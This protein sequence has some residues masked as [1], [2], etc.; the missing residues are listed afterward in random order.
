MGPVF[1]TL[2]KTI[3][4][5]KMFISKKKDKDDFECDLLELDSITEN[6]GEADEIVYYAE[7]QIRD[8]F[9]QKQRW[10]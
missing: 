7:S 10:K 8:W 2:I 4:F 5:P 3:C 6:L 9:D 1:A